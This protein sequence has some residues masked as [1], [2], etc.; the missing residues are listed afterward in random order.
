MFPGD[1]ET[2]LE[3]GFLRSGRRFKSGKRRKNMLRTRI[4][5]IDQEE[6]G[7]ELHHI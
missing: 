5:N 4:C 2:E 3:P 1:S 6:E 7:Y